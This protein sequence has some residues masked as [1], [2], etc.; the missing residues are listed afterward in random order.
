MRRSLM[1]QLGLLA[2]ALLAIALNWVG[3][4]EPITDWIIRVFD[5]VARP[6]A[7]SV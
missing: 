5:R 3:W 4:W 7:A 6:D 1:W 2:V